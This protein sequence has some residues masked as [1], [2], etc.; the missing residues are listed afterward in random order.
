[1][2]II[3][4]VL[5]FVSVVSIG[6]AR[7]NTFAETEDFVFSD[8]E[9]Y[10]VTFY[11]NGQRLTVKTTAITVGEALERAGIVLNE[12]D[13]VEPKLDEKINSDNFFINIYRSHP[14]D[15]THKKRRQ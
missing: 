10:F 11:D 9:D 15:G 7:N 12:T 3:I 6:Q 14:A 13:I 2:A 4:L 5:S 1:M 8:T